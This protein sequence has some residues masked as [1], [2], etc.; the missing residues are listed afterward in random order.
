[1]LPGQIHQS[2]ERALTGSC[3]VQTLPALQTLQKVRVHLLMRWCSV[4]TGW[5]QVLQH[6]PPGR[7]LRMQ[8]VLQGL[9]WLAGRRLGR[10]MLE[11]GLQALHQRVCFAHQTVPWR[12]SW[13]KMELPR[14]LLLE[15][16]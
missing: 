2:S 10:E 14:Y 1:M 16:H 11:T 3:S 12:G 9:Q 8:R 4:Q 7:S 6:W 5:S 15:P 13:R